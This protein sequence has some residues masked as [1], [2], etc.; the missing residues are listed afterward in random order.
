MSHLTMDPKNGAKNILISQ[1]AE[2][3]RQ[4]ATTDMLICCG[5]HHQWDGSAHH[6]R[7]DGQ[8]GFVGFD[9]GA[10]HSHTA[11]SKCLSVAAACE[12]WTGDEIEFGL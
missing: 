12:H 2:G 5:S 7:C 8:F 6:T 9:L 11:T 3:F 4:S 1:P 10:T